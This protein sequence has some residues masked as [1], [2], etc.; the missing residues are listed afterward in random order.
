MLTASNPPQN[1]LES[2]SQSKTLLGKR[3]SSLGLDLLSL[4]E[5]RIQD[6]GGPDVAG[7]EE[8]LDQELERFRT[9][10]LDASEKGVLLVILR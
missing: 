1:L 6:L 9:S 3:I 4:D 2:C 7:I 5:H 8:G 10:P